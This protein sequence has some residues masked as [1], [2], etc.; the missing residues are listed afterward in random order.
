MSI[1]SL[2]LRCVVVV[3]VA[4]W[5]AGVRAQKT[6][7]RPGGASAQTGT[8]GQ[9][10]AASTQTGAGAGQKNEAPSNPTSPQKTAGAKTGEAGS[11]VQGPDRAPATASGPITLQG[12]ING[13]QQAYTFTQTSTSTSFALRGDAGQLSAARGKLVELTARQF[14]PESNRGMK[15]LPILSVEKLQ[16]IADEC[17][18]PAAQGSM[19][20]AAATPGVGAATS[21]ANTQNT[22]AATPRYQNPGAP[23]QTPASIGT[24]PNNVGRDAGAPSPGTGNPPPKQTTP[25]PP[26]PPPK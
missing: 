24:N 6:E 13:G 12:C 15:N 18:P 17:P 21:G 14:P 4:G 26:P 2:L 11:N 10:G 1:N 9:T 8:A 3:A 25:P 22:G 20:P 5:T 23:N 19:A 16:V 7:P